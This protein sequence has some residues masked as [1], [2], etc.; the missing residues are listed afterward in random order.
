MAEM[1]IKHQAKPSALLASRQHTECF[2]LPIARARPCFSYFKEITHE[3][4]VKAY[5]FQVLA[6]RSLTSSSQLRQLWMISYANASESVSRLI[7]TKCT[8]IPQLVSLFTIR[9]SHFT[10]LY[11][12]IAL[13]M[14]FQCYMANIALIFALILL[15]LNIYIY[16]RI[17]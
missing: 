6:T 9:F 10:V 5:P 2:I 3:R 16:T 12:N 17:I 4:L 8:W 13:Q 7:L 11:C 15:S 14:C 1:P